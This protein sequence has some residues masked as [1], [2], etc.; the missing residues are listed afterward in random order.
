MLETYALSYRVLRA[1]HEKHYEEPARYAVLTLAETA[2]LLDDPSVR[3]YTADL[4]TVG[5]VLV[6][7]VARP[8]AVE[9]GIVYRVFQAPDGVTYLVML[10]NW[11]R[12]GTPET[13]FR[14]WPAEIGFQAQTFFVDGGLVDNTSGSGPGYS[15][16]P[17]TPNTL[18]CVFRNFADPLEFFRL[19]L[20][21]TEAFAMKRGLT[22]VPQESI[23]KFNRRQETIHEEEQEW[24]RDHPYS[25]ADHLRFYLQM[26][27]T[28]QR[29]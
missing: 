22:P 11:I 27:R 23:D 3:K 24:N 14:I 21:A 17:P 16:Q 26:P 6:G 10:C 8:P 28:E 18:R 7:D 1:Q 15:R 5:F 13:R 4:S 12:T 2:T 25:W 9:A 29:S 20:A 19:H